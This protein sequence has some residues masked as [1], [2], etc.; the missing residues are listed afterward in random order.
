M[1]GELLSPYETFISRKDWIPAAPTLGVEV[2]AWLGAIVPDGRAP[3]NHVGSAVLLRVLLAPLQG[4]DE[5]LVAV[6]P[7][8]ASLDPT[9]K[10]GKGGKKW[11][12][13]I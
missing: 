8:Q 4:L 2:V 5:K 1:E 10:Q 3:I 6:C 11:C 9:K 7:N 13:F 12:G